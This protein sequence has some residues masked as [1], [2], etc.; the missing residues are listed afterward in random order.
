ME[1]EPIHKADLKPIKSMTLGYLNLAQYHQRL[2]DAHNTVVV[3]GL[4][5]ILSMKGLVGL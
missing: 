4:N 1:K 5:E 3:T 2:I